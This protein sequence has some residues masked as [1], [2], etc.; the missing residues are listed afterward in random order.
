MATLEELGKAFEELPRCGG[1]HVILQLEIFDPPPQQYVK[2]LV[3][4]Q[5]EP[6]AGIAQQ[7]VAIGMEGADFQARI[8]NLA[9]CGRAIASLPQACDAFQQ[10]ARGVA[11][12]SNRQDLPR[13]CQPFFDEANHAA[14]QHGRLPRACARDHQHR[15]MHMLYGRELLWCGGK[16]FGLFD[17]VVLFRLAEKMH[18]PGCFHRGL[19]T[20]KKRNHIMRYRVTPYKSE[21]S[22]VS[23][24]F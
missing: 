16:Y 24:E 18:L 2:V 19:L 7:Q 17:G 14:G 21:N 10:I 20:K 11:R 13:F 3:V 6:L 8:R 22:R 15:S 4:D 23:A 12:V 1:L 9:D 5:V